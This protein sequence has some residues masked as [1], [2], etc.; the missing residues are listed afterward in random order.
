MKKIKYWV[1]SIAIL[2][3]CS[4]IKLKNF[5]LPQ[6]VDTTSRPIELQEK[7]VFHAGDVSADNLFDGARLNDFTRVNDS[8]Y[9][10]VI[11]PENEPINASPHYAFRIQSDKEQS[12][13]L[14][15]TYPTH[16]HRYWPKLSKDGINWQPIDSTNFKLTADGKNAE[17]ALQI[18][19]HPLWIAAQEIQN[20]EHNLSWAKSLSTDPRVHFRIAGKS[21][22][23]RDL[24]LLDL[25]DGSP[26]KKEMLVIVSRQHPPEVTGYLAM[27]SFVETLLGDTRIA[28]DFIKKYRI[29]VFPMANPDGVDLGHWR[30]NAGGIDLNRDWAFYRQEEIKILVNT[31]VNTAKADQNK[32]ILGLDFHSTQED[33][34]YTLPAEARPGLYPFK[35]YWLDAINGALP[36]YTPDEHPD[37][38]GQPVTK[39]WFYNQFNA[40]AV[41]YEIGD[42]TSRDFIRQK[43]QVAADEMM[44]LLIL[45]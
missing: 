13:Y 12:V 20:S 30:H 28:K 41:I 45:R 25:Y 15:L 37:P 38:F 4:G 3:G 11:L 14:Q 31:I 26:Q 16:Q 1:L 5:N 39:T 43:A 6:P 18:D 32:V 9:Q 36:D 44:K 2:Q 35:N 34:Y 40:D 42:E 8:T 29:L 27:K 22:L 7:K 21:K 10:A 17:L 23:G 24:L 33:L 19:K